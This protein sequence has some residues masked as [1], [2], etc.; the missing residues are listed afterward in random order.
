MGDAF[1]NYRIERRRVI[2][3]I[4]GD[5][6]IGRQLAPLGEADQVWL[7]E[8]LDDEIKAGI[9][10]GFIPER[11]LAVSLDLVTARCER[12]MWRNAVAAQQQGRAS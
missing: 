5:I 2:R 8:V 9:A 6:F 7:L 1:G 4:M 12:T 10:L 3:H 11:Q